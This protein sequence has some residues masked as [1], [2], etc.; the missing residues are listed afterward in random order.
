MDHMVA[1]F[2]MLFAFFAASACVTSAHVGDQMTGTASWYGKGYQGK[3]TA[4]GEIFDQNKLTAAHKSLPFNTKVKVANQNNGKSVVV[5][6]NDRMPQSNSRLIDLSHAAAVQIDMIKAGIVEVEMTI[7][8][9][10]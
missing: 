10:K 4:N 2:F 6:I 3:K 5:R 9:L 8:N 7:L 1:R